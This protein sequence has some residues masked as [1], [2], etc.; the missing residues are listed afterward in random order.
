[1]D[2][3]KAKNILIFMFLIINMFLLYQ[4]YATNRNQYKY[5]EKSE[6]ASVIEYLETKS[7]QMNTEIPSSVTIIPALKVKYFEFDAKAVLKAFYTDNNNSFKEYESG[8]NIDNGSLAIGVKDKMH[9]SYK[10]RTISIDSHKVNEDQCLKQ[11]YAFIEKLQ[12]NISN[13]YILHKEVQKGAL[14]LV[15]GQQYKKIPVEN[16]RIEILATEEGVV[17][18]QVS[19][20]E[21]MGPDKRENLITPVMA[22]LRVFENRSITDSPITV[23]QIRQGYYFDSSPQ[24]QNDLHALVEGIAYPMWVIAYD[25]NEVYI[26]A[27]NQEHEKV[28]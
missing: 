23:N 21:Y 10:D 22:L 24:S 2:W 9:L 7:I 1:M 6:I 17:E 28:K 4:L 11:A 15:L 25:N 18:A 13:K 16:S 19:W 12:L 26:N 5:I 20:F 3:R 8:F 27:Y 14:K